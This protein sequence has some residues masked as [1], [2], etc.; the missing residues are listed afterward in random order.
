MLALDLE[1]G[2]IDAVVDKVW[3]DFACNSSIYFKNKTFR[4]FHD[5]KCSRSVEGKETLIC[6]ILHPMVQLVR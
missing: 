3:K 6:R 1:D 2:S 4:I 5:H